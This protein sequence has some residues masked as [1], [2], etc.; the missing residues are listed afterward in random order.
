MHLRPE[1]SPDKASRGLIVRILLSV[2]GNIFEKEA[3]GFELES[4]WIRGVFWADN[5]DKRLWG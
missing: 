5:S 1:S 3:E 4:N 2:Y